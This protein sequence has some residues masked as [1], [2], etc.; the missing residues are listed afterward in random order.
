MSKQK[1]LFAVA[2]LT[3]IAFTASAQQHLWTDPNGWWNE[4]FTT[5]PDAPR[6]TANELTLDA[7]GSFLAPERRPLDLFKTNLRRGVW[8]G[9]MGLNYFF[10]RYFGFGADMDLPADGGHLIDQF[11][12]NLIG[13][14]P[15]GNSGLAPYLFGGGG[16]TIDP[17]F[18]PFAQVGVGLEY[19]FNPFTGI[20]I[21]TRYEWPE[22]TTDMIMFRSGLRFAF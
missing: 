6:Y 15:I 1:T 16:G 20:F 18:Q 13:R 17:E 11:G 10:S 12:G 22:H 21:D 3:V 19:R 4:H 14:I 8:G 9:G 7:F 5:N 2:G